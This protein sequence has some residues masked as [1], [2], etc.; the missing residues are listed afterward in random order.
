MAIKYSKDFSPFKPFA[1]RHLMTIASALWVR[2]FKDLIGQE[3]RWYVDVTDNSKVLVDLN[4]NQEGA[5]K[6][7]LLIVIHG[8]E[9][10]SRSHYV[11]GVAS[12]AYRQGFSTARMNLRNCG[13]TAH[14][15]DTLYNAGMSQDVIKVANCA[16]EEHGFKNVILAGYSLGGNIVL[17]AAS[18]LETNGADW[19]KAVIGVSPSVDLS[20]AVDQLELGINRIYEFTFLRSLKA[21]IREKAKRYPD[22]FRVQEL[23]S[24][25]TVRE[26]DEYFTA[27]DGG[28][29]S[30]SHYYASAS[31]IGF[32]KD[33]KK[34]VLII[35]SQDDPIVPF[36]SFED[37]RF[38]SDNI[39]VVA[40][41]SGGHGAFL[42]SLKGK[43]GEKRPDRFWAEDLVSEFSLLNV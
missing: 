31:A 15:T 28:Y 29:D 40:P 18:E 35:A 6:D 36:E 30:A 2:N 26:F 19:L 23:K 39:E 17:K 33:I 7:T 1:D 8:L 9:G 43:N 37:S 4:I 24:V 3:T 5:H 25:K 27:A 10:C 20:L 13:G 41:L 38:K 16:M 21:K 14:L 32:V 42:G 34:P 12:K 22:K 11:C